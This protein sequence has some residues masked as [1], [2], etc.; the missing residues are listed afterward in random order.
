MHRLAVLDSDHTILADT[1][2]SVSQHP[3]HLLLAVG[4]D[5]GY[6][7]NALAALHLPD[8]STEEKNS[9]KIEGREE[10]EMER[11]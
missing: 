5:G 9:T 3:A 2:H 11:A 7:H 6:L 10:R 1:I 8:E 4:R